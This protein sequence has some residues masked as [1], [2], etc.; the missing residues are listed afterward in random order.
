MSV[1]QHQESRVGGWKVFFC[2]TTLTEEM[3][4]NN[5][6]GLLL[7]LV[8]GLIAWL[9]M[10]LILQPE[11]RLSDSLKVRKT[12]YA[13]PFA[14]AIPIMVWARTVFLRGDP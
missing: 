1:P 4:T 11:T 3:K 10:V 5:I 8:V 9:Q 2:S 6:W 12:Y 13:L 7:G 14:V